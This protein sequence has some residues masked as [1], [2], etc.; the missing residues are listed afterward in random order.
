MIRIHLTP[1]QR[2]ALQALRRDSSLT[3]AERDRVEMVFLSA[4]GWAPPAIARHLNCCVAT[5]RRLLK[6][7]DLNDLTSLRRQRPGPAPATERRQAVEAALCELLAEDRTWTA[8]QLAAA[9]GARGI[10]LASRTVRRYLTRLGARYRRTART[11]RHK[12]DPARVEAAKKELAELIKRAIAGDILLAYLDECGFSPSPP[13]NASWT[14]PRER[15]WAPYENPQGRRLNTLAALVKH[16]PRPSLTWHTLD[17]TFRS[18]DFLEFVR[19]A[20]PHPGMELVF[21]LD[22]G[23]LHISKEVKAVLP[24]LEQAGIRL[25]FLPPYSPELNAIEAVFGTIKYQGMPE[26]R[27]KSN[28]DLY[29]AIDAAFEEAEARLLARTDAHRKTQQQLRPAA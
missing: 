6:R 29:L 15:K 12:Q 5:V 4:D 18:A 28:Y 7:V 20:V 25:Y 1:D 2:Q 26:R 14:L 21:V 19:A 16:G 24:E 13:V 10:A 9:L 11:L 27:Y 8:G 3:P 22:N 23:S 17:R